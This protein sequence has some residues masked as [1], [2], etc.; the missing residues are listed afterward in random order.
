M[1]LTC[2]IATYADRVFSVRSN[3]PSGTAS[4]LQNAR[5]PYEPKFISETS[6]RG[7]QPRYIVGARLLDQ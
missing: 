6:V 3:S 4:L 7:F 5:L 1:V 2:V